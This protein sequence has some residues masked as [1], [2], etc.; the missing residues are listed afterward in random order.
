MLNTCI[1]K[2]HDLCY[3]M[4]AHTQPF[5]V[6][7]PSYYQI[8]TNVRI[9][10]TDLIMTLNCGLCQ[11]GFSVLSDRLIIKLSKICFHCTYVDQM[12]LQQRFNVLL[13]LQFYNIF[14]IMFFPFFS[15]VFT[16]ILKIYELPKIYIKKPKYCQTLVW[17]I[18][19]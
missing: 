10:Q 12:N 14:T 8:W 18:I 16:D 2:L 15:K 19:T 1:S 13:Q 3:F 9:C 6:Y 11:S 7:Q 17:T 4:I 5:F